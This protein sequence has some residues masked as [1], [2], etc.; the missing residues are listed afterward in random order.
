MYCIIF[1]RDYLNLHHI[2]SLKFR[3]SCQRSALPLCY[4]FLLLALLAT[5]SAGYKSSISI[6]SALDSV[7]VGSAME[8]LLMALRVRLSRGYPESMLLSS[9][10]LSTKFCSFLSEARFSL[11]RTVAASRMFLICSS[12]SPR[13]DWQRPAQFCRA[14][15]ISGIVPGARSRRGATLVT[16]TV[17]R[18]GSRVACKRPA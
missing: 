4:N 12:R 11:S 6:S 8:R 7:P 10:T 3:L 2:G 9:L 14:L 15:I 13:V 17:W 1:R 5:S 16:E 18:A